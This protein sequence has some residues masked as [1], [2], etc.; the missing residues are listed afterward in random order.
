MEGYRPKK[1]LII[2]IVQSWAD[3]LNLVVGNFDLPGFQS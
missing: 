3:Q 2:I 1:I